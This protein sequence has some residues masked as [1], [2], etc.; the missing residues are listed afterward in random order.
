M[1]DAN[2]Q[3]LQAPE[4]GPTDS[5]L[6]VPGVRV[7]QV[8]IGPTEDAPGGS[9]GVTAVVTADGSLGAVDV[10]GAAPATRET[11]TL[12]AVAS[13]ERVHAIVLSGRSVFGLAAADG[14]TAELEA[15]GI[16]LPVERP[17]GRLTIPIVA[18]A[19]LFDFAHGDRSVR[20]GPADGRAAIA[21]ALD[22]DA[23]ERPRSGNAGAGAGATTGS[24]AEPRLKGGVGHASA[25][26]PVAGQTSLVVA[27]TAVVNSAGSLVDPGSGKPWAQWGGFHLDATAPDFSAIAAA[28]RNT[29]L[30]VLATNARLDKAQLVRVAAMAHD[31][32]ARAIRPAHTSVDG[33][34]VFALGL[35]ET[36]ERPVV[37]VHEWAAAG[38]TV[39]GSLAADAVTRAVLDAL[40]AAHSSGGFRAYR[41]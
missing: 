27:A 22:D 12:T 17:E 30:V 8:E 32:L 16:G 9:T 39:V 28:R 33:D 23:T 14:A 36:D 31:G 35:R 5:L 18:A 40:L 20:P 15:R 10:R 26:L 25:V 21:A 11:D 37:A 6:D 13:G 41:S 38:V 3:A 19:A 29:T 7:G 34:V 24:I 4:P 1:S 2:G